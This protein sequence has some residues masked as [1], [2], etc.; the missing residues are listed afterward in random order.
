M[1][2]PNTLQSI[3]DALEDVAEG[4]LDEQ[5]ALLRI[6]AA[7]DELDARIKKHTHEPIVLGARAT[8]RSSG[9]PCEIVG[10]A[11]PVDSENRVGKERTVVYRLLGRLFARDLKDFRD[12]FVVDP[13][14]TREEKL[15][16]L[17]RSALRDSVVGA[18]RRAGAA[19]N[20]EGVDGQIDQL[21]P[22]VDAMI[23][24]V[25]EAELTDA[26]IDNAL[27]WHTD[28]LS[29]AYSEKVTAHLPELM[30]RVQDEVQRM[31][32]PVEI[33][34]G[35]LERD[36]RYLVGRRAGDRAYVGC[37][38]F[39]GGKIIE[40][41][42]PEQTLVR[43]WHEELGVHIQVVQTLGMCGTRDGAQRFRAQ[44][45]RV[46]LLHA[47]AIQLDTARLVR[48]PEVYSEIAWKTFEE[49]IALVRAHAV[50]A[51]TVTPC[52]QPLL[53]VLYRRE[54]E[55]DPRAKA[56][57]GL[58]GDL[59]FCYL[60]GPSV[61]GSIPVEG[62]DAD[63]VLRGEVDPRVVWLKD[64]Q[65][66]G[67]EMSGIDHIEVELY[68]PGD[69]KSDTAVQV[70]P[71]QYVIGTDGAFYS[72]RYKG[73]DFITCMVSRAKVYASQ[74]EATG[75]LAAWDVAVWPRGFAAPPTC[76]LRSRALLEESRQLRPTYIAPL[77]TTS[78]IHIEDNSVEAFGA[79]PVGTLVRIQRYVDAKER[80]G[81]PRIAALGQAIAMLG[82]VARRVRAEDSDADPL[83]AEAF[84][85]GIAQGLREGHPAVEGFDVPD[86]SLDAALSF[87]GAV[88]DVRAFMQRGQPE[89]LATELRAPVV[90]KG[91]AWSQI[92]WAMNKCFAGARDLSGCSQP[93]G[94]SARL[95]LEEL[96]EVLD[97]LLKGD[98]EG[99]ADNLVDLIYVA[100]GAGLRCG[101]PLAEVWDAVHR[102]NMAKYPT[103]EA[104]V[105]IN[106]DLECGVCNG[107]GFRVFRDA[108]GKVTKPPGWAPPNITA[109]LERRRG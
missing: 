109:V 3:R 23:L 92:E 37:W 31:L 67:I 40:G 68:A 25:L 11:L 91:Q 5:A 28:P 26:E 48:N 51:P 10:V 56:Q 59:R 94:V 44:F 45:S 58:D 87:E 108:A 77:P 21:V 96:S 104:C 81:V 34:V 98:L 36:G 101:I 62:T 72:G 80:E 99:Y 93:D 66:L 43:E 18:M 22:K 38:E 97:A 78:P 20:I 39:P 8:S 103:C 49:I 73:S 27:A 107:R 55:G 53:D 2:P 29:I 106:P 46:D 9:A 17:M 83:G 71:P 65:A 79:D 24:E 54:I 85:A 100:I 52:M 16:D 64:I 14:R 4:R 86:C 13:P 82:E 105:G 7:I 88:E 89:Q 15:H 60:R 41:E 35:L 74:P 33:A 76:I 102:A 19:L 63:R 75:D 30:V 61:E 6:G 12:R 84:G 70:W 50:E 32:A 42:T 90:A 57:A 95:M 1:S 47:A 69:T